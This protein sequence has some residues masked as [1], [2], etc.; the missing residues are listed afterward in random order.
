MAAPSPP[1]PRRLAAA[2]AGAMAI[3]A[4]VLVVA[5]LPAEYGLDP[6]GMGAAIGFVRPNDDARPAAKD[7]SEDPAVRTVYEMRATWRLLAMPLAQADG[8][9]SRAEPEQRVVVPLGVANLTS[10][11]AVLTWDDAD[12]IDGRRTEG[13]T[14]EISIQAPGGQRSALAQAKNEPGLPGTASATLSLRSVPFPDA[15][16]GQLV[17]PTAPDRTGEGNWTFLVRLYTAGG[18]EG[19]AGRDPGQAWTLNVTGE[20]YDME[21]RA[22]AGR[23]A[24]RVSFS[25]APR[26]GIEYKFFMREG[27]QMQYAWNST[28][29]VEWDFHADEAGKDPEDF[30]S[31][32]T[33]MSDGEEGEHLAPFMGRHGWY[34]VNKG[35]QP[36]TLALTTTGDY[37]ILGVIH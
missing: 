31:F 18:L 8:Y 32:A 19:S 27:A 6:T 23:P 9:S 24:D 7:A 11:T 1:T 15:E 33:G 14:L 3:A 2:T 30:T 4:A 5:V 17:V 20:A 36:V 37:D 13:D 29:P 10:V 25:L 26:Q 35:A 16:A 21:V 34:W 22:E 28:G 12:V